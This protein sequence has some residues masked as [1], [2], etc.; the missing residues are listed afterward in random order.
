MPIVFLKAYFCEKVDGEHTVRF[1][2]GPEDEH[3]LFEKAICDDDSVEICLAQY[4]C[5]VDVDD[6]LYPPRPIKGEVK[7]KERVAHGLHRND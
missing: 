6:L 4:I 7:L 2:C 3:K 5:S 1:I